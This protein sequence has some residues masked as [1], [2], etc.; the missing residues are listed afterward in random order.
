[1]QTEP[2]ETL[3][4]IR[5]NCCRCAAGATL[6]RHRTAGL[7]VHVYI[8]RPRDEGR[9]STPQSFPNQYLEDPVATRVSLERK[10]C[11]YLCGTGY[12]ATS[13]AIT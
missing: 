5:R 11:L 8:S 4:M 6:R 13:I 12:S 9:P 7:L 1:M 10:R 3:V 2:L